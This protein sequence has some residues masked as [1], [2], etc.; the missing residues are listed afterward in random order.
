MYVEVYDVLTIV[1]RIK[2]D[3]EIKK[4]FVNVDLEERVLVF[5]FLVDYSVIILENP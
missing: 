5:D 3:K 4:A 1:Y 2:M